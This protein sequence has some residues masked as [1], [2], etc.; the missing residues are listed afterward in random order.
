MLYYF[1]K[2]N[3]AIFFILFYN[4]II[5]SLNF[6]IRFSCIVIRYIIVISNYKYVTLKVIFY[7]SITIQTQIR[8]PNTH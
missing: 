4:T 7:T 3:F 5:I 8:L 2:R 1:L 6:T